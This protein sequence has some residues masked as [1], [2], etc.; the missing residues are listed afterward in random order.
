MQRAASQMIII[1]YGKSKTKKACLLFNENNLIF[2][3]EKIVGRKHGVIT[4]ADVRTML[5]T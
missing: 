3:A 1:Q 2:I 5:P 4:S